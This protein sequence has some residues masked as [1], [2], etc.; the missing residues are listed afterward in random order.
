MKVVVIGQNEK[1][2][3]LSL[4]HPEEVE[5]N[6]GDV[7]AFSTDKELRLVGFDKNLYRLSLSSWK[8]LK[9]DLLKRGYLNIGGRLNL[10][11]EIVR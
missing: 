2:E 10:S 3:I 7:T 5:I 11:R 1:G 9:K 6:L 8:T 4:K